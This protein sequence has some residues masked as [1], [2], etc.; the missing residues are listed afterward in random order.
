MVILSVLNLDAA[1]F[2]CTFGRGCDGVC[3]RNGRPL[4][5]PEEAARIDEVLPRI[6]PELRPSARMMVQRSGY[7]SRRRKRGQPVARVVEGWCVFF[8]KGCVLHRVGLSAGD[9]LRYKPAVC[10]LFP[11]DRDHDGQWYVRQKG[12]NGEIW[13]LPCLDPAASPVRAADSLKAELAL[14]AGFAVSAEC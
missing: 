12:Y 7:V 14:A 4:I 1:R 8:N 9:A 10:G 6:I 2:D 13:D 3:C 11:L 5:Y